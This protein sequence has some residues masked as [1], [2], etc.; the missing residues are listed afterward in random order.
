MKIIT[1]VDASN[2]VSFNGKT[3]SNDW[4]IARYKRSIARITMEAT[5]NVIRRN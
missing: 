4:W 3:L 1:L 5:Y 2:N